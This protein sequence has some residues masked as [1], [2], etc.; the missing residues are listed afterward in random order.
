MKTIGNVLYTIIIFFVLIL[1]G[2]KSETGSS[3]LELWY[4]Q[5]AGEW[6]E[7][8]PIGNGRLG[9]MIYGGVEKETI[10]L[11]ESSMWSG[12]YDPEQEQAFGKERMKEL[13]KLFFDGKLSEGNNIAS[14]YLVGSSRSFGT[15]LPVGDLHIDFKYPSGEISN[16]K[17]ALNL[18]NA[19]NEVVF[20]IGD[21]QYKREYFCSNPDD[22]MIVRMTANKSA[23]LSMDFYLNLL[24]EA[25]ISTNDSELIFSGKVNFPKHGV[26]GVNFVGIITIKTDEGTVATNGGKLSITNADA[27]TVAVD[28]RTDYK[29]PDYQQQNLNTVNKAMSKNY[30]DLKANH[31]SDYS[32][33]FNR[34]QLNLGKSEYEHLPTDVRW[35]QLKEGK[36]DVGLDALFFQ[37][38]RYL[39]IAASRENSPLPAALQGM[40]NDN[41]ACNMGWTNDYHLDINTQQNYWIANIGNLHECHKPLFRYIKDLSV[42]GS[43]T[44]G[45]V[46]GCRGWT[47][48]TVAN[49]WGYTAPSQSISWGL[50]PT[51]SSWI[52]S[53]L[54]TQYQYTLDKT[55]LAEEA[56]PLLKGNAIFLLD[57]MVEDTEHTYLMSGPG[58]SPENGFIYKGERLCASMMPACDRQLAY[59]IFKACLE[60]TEIL[61]IDQ[62]FA[63][64]LKTAL[65]KLP[66][67]MIGKNGAIQEWFEDYEEGSP[68]HRHTSHLLSFYPFSQITLDKTPEL[69]KAAKKTIEYRLAAEGWEDTEWSR[70]NMICF[71]ARLKDPSEAY[72]SLVMLQSDFS[73]ENL[74]T[75]SP[76]GIAGAPYDIF[77][78]DG[79]TAGAAG[80]GEMLIQTQEGYVEFL[81]CLPE[82]WNNGNFKG[83]CIPGGAEVSVTWNNS[84][85]SYASLKATANNTFSVKLPDG[86]DYTVTI[87]NKKI[88][89]AS[90][91]DII[92]VEMRI[93]DLFEI[94]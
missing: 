21:I 85:I 43:K 45:K 54:W 27:V 71:Y 32:P 63:D 41:L 33:L 62:T 55:F 40:W 51:A 82:A 11:N 83:L 52:A 8:T 68:N 10:A 53:H 6:M 70:A 19:V 67:I 9:A 18:E 87:N 88:S 80:I 29:N 66:P 58:I 50:F 37:Y 57:Y 2:C 5:P 36:N 23:S 89:A 25:E 76:A 42:H 81:P 39:L 69:A 73:R 90:D 24:R 47:A 94:K 3:P 93:G 16:Y 15:H 14:K 22:A 46:Y 17:R 59:E 60:T 4:N 30:S 72:K 65:S 48:H 64:S 77:V 13:R 75:I 92:E 44:A 79:N 49:I 56:Y 20:H 78:L 28:I 34:V 84:I 38:G 31:I 74:M 7:A 61:G 26:G 1:N 35:K 12:E 86:K 91:N